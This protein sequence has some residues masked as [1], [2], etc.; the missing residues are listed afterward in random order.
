MIA[1]PRKKRECRDPPANNQQAQDQMRETFGGLTKKGIDQV[2]IPE[3][4]RDK[5][6]LL[7]Q[8]W[9]I[10]SKKQLAR[11]TQN[12]ETDKQDE[13]NGSTFAILEDEGL[14]DRQKGK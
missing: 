5:K 12:Q 9:I 13:V 10:V 14:E 8:N 6:D 1:N 2:D 11:Q 4:S 3:S 7:R